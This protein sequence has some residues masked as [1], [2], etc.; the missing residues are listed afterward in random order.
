VRGD[1]EHPVLI[2]RRDDADLTGPLNEIF[3]P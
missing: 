1:S 2:G 3:Q